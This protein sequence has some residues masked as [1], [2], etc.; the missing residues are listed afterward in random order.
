MKPRLL[1]VLGIFAG[2][3]SMGRV[4]AD[5]TSV[6]MRPPEELDELFG[7]IALYP[8]ALIALILP[9]STVPSDVVMAARYLNSNGD[10]TKIDD[11]GWDDSV[12]D[13][14]HYPDLIKW[15]DE[16]LAWTKQAG[17]AFVAQQD[18]VMNSIQRLRAKARAAGTLVDTPQQQVVVEGDAISIIPTQPDV[19]YVPSYDP[20]VV[21]VS[22]PG[23]L[24]SEP[25]LNFGIGYATGFWLGYDFDWGRHRIWTIDRA[26]R[27]RYWRE[28][29]DWRRPYYP[30]RPGYGDNHLHQ[31]PWHPPVHAAR[32]PSPRPS[33]NNRPRPEIQRPMPYSNGGSGHRSDFHR[34][35]DVR[36][37]NRDRNSNSPGQSNG[38]PETGLKPAT[39]VVPATPSSRPSFTPQSGPNPNARPAQPS[40]TQNEKGRDDR[41][42]RS[43]D[44]SDGAMNSNPQGR[45]MPLQPAPQPQRQSQSQSSQP[46]A[47]FHSRPPAPTT[48]PR[49][50]APPSRAQQEATYSRQRRT[51]QP[52]QQPQHSRD[53]DREARDRRDSRQ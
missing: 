31:Q 20:D 41:D 37:E 38:R 9:A 22:R 1:L 40:P 15:L 46:T 48:Q 17:E 51:E 52:Q 39:V 5:E 24:Y 19:I 28:R 43:R 42:S 7:P 29:R 53:S 13:L 23:V 12:V 18:D 8:D 45:V 14:M 25:F 36:P 34:G 21:Y 2:L 30:G 35:P 47:R 33:G 26:D 16:N 50:P 3:L 44:R 4:F 32:P 6:R 11:Q 10:M 27:E 49:A